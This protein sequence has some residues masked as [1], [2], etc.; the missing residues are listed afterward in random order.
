[1]QFVPYTHF[2][3]FL[4]AHR[5]RNDDEIS[6]PIRILL[7]LNRAKMKKNCLDL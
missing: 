2:V 5:F 4:I 7:I 1:M 6:E 3:A